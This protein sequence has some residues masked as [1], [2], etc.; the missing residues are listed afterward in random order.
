MELIF[1]SLL[2]DSA[3]LT[4]ETEKMASPFRGRRNTPFP[5][6]ALVVH[7]GMRTVELFWS[8][9]PL[10]TSRSFF[11]FCFSL[12]SDGR[13]FSHVRNQNRQF[14][15]PLTQ[16]RRFDTVVSPHTPSQCQQQSLLFLFLP[17]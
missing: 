5:L 7:H 16:R 9:L 15:V 6:P 10:L 17:T 13:E 12:F 14:S 3:D 8:I 11:L 1:F 4:V 2:I